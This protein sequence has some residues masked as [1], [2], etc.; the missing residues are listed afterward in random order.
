LVRDDEARQLVPASLAESAIVLTIFE[1][2]GLEFNDVLLWNFFSDSPADK[3]WRCLVDYWDNLSA[4]SQS[5]GSLND[6]S[7]GGVEVRAESFE[8]MDGGSGV[9]IRGLEF[10]EGRYALLE[11]ELKA[12]YCA[13][14]RARINVWI[15]DFDKQKRSPAFYWFSNS[16][17]V[18]VIYKDSA[19]SLSTSGGATKNSPRDFQ[20][21]GIY[22]QEMAFTHEKP[23]GLLETAITCF[24]QAGA[25]DLMSAALAQIAAVGVSGVQSSRSSQSKMHD[26]PF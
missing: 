8:T 15:V 13:L 9:K 1:A 14:T 6:S 19:V 21:R 12:L 17:L 3:E 16:G 20:K 23:E 18:D 10:E 2:K 11:S 5:E 7:G 25:E 24:R 22:F 4:E 26:T